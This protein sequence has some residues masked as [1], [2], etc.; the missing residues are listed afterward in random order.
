MTFGIFLARGS[1]AGAA[2]KSGDAAVCGVPGAAPLPPN[3]SK[4]LH[5]AGVFTFLGVRG[6]EERGQNYKMLDFGPF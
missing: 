2:L 3:P 1:A 4:I 5:S 6:R